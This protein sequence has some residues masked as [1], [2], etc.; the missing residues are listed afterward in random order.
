VLWAQRQPNLFI[1]IDLQSVDKDAVTVELTEEKIYFRGKGGLD[2]NDYELTLNLY[3]PIDLETSTKGVNARG[4]GFL[5][6][7]KEKVWWPRLVKEGKLKYIKVDWEK[8]KE[9]DDEEEG[10]RYKGDDFGMD[11]Y[12]D[13]G[14]GFFCFVVFLFG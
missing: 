13:I 14:G 8:W 12:S 11:G 7:K 9:E 10:G 1:T 4:V 2:Q 6:N 3:A 5:L